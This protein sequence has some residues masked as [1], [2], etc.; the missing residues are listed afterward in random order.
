[1]WGTPGQENGAQGDSE[2]SDGTGLG[3]SESTV[4]AE[5]PRKVSQVWRTA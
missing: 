1:M 2:A 4:I 5:P 3:T